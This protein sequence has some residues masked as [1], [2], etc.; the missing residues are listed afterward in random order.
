MKYPLI[1]VEEK[2]HR[3]LQTGEKSLV[4]RKA[5]V[6]DHVMLK[7]QD[8]YTAEDVR[9]LVASLGMQIRKES[10][11]SGYFLVS[12]EGKDVHALEKSLT[13]LKSQRA[14]AQPEP[15]YVAR[16][17]CRFSGPDQLSSSSGIPSTRPDLRPLSDEAD[18]RCPPSRQPLRYQS[19]IRH[20]WL[21]SDVARDEFPEDGT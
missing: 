11:I 20:S 15:D 3:D 10:A 7:A 18:D 19:W 8:G 14:V 2:Y 21:H 6:A 17:N 13:T 16:S 9:R 5:M 12:F 1:R 4:A